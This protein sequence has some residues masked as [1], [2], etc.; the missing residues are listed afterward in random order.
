MKKFLTK[1]IAVFLLLCTTAAIAE[2]TTDGFGFDD[3]TETGSAFSIDIGGRLSLGGSF[4][5]N[6]FKTFKDVQPGSLIDG[7]LHIHATAP[8]TEAYFGV[9][10][11][12]KTLA[13]WL[14]TTQS[15]YPA[16]P[17][18]APWID[19]AYLKMLF[20]PA[21]ITGGIQKISWGRAET[22]SVLDIVN[23]HDQ[24]DLTL[25]YNPQEMKIARP[26]I[27][28][29]VYLP[30]D[31]KLETVFL[32]VFEGNRIVTGA[33]DRWYS[34]RFERLW[35][36]PAAFHQPATNTLSY[37]Q[38]GGRLTAAVG[39]MHDFGIQ[40]FYGRLPE[41][42]FKT[43]PIGSTIPGSMGSG[44]GSVL[45][46]PSRKII[47][48]VYNPYHHIGID[49]GLGIGPVALSAELAANITADIA[50][51][52]PSV[53]NPALAW[54]IGVVYTAPLGFSLNLTAAETIRLKHT[55]TNLHPH[56]VEYGRKAT[57]TKV[58]FSVAQTLL[59]S[60]FE[61]KLGMLIGLED[62]DFCIMPGIHWQLATLLIDCNVG[63]FG[64]SRAGRLG[65]FYRNS[66]IRL[67]AAYEF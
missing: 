43:E 15:V 50:G 49:Y 3:N 29:T 26:L 27:S 31:L 24:T 19:E 57:D 66:F 36:L 40:Y 46:P 55:Q 4:F 52:D 54:N 42:A 67:T 59:R 9:R 47:A 14:G 53:Y 63:I 60:S 16:Q 7:K 61:W 56:D 44:G 13:P 45:A 39:G 2:E 10:L 5:F 37:A 20:G 33:S 64:G 28:T 17:Q 6:D 34:R 11:N 12:G 18:I 1:W 23:P 32:P 38:G 48:G 65:Q 8:L 30:H 35:G 62:A 25:M 58:S 41:P 51:N 22:L 21:V